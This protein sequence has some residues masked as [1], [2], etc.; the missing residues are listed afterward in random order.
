M[1]VRQWSFLA[2]I[3]SLAP[4]LICSLCFSTRSAR[5]HRSPFFLFQQVFAWQITALRVQ[6]LRAYRVCLLIVMA[7]PAS[8]CAHCSGA[9]LSLILSSR[10]VPPAAQHFPVA[11]TFWRSSLLLECTFCNL[12][13]RRKQKESVRRSF[14]ISQTVSLFVIY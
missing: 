2:F 3:S 11:R 5:L 10:R 1:L 6:A 13:Q 12:W 4:F 9:D 14:V 8:S 7:S